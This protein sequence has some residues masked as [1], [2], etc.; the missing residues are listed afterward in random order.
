MIGLKISQNVQKGEIIVNQANM[1]LA[2]FIYKLAILWEV[3][4]TEH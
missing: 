3:N 2:I 4:Q 1:A